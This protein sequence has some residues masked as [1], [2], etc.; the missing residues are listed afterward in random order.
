M[1]ERRDRRA[2]R[3]RLGRLHR[4]AYKFA[5]HTATDPAAGLGHPAQA[6]RRKTLLTQMRCPDSVLRHAR[7]AGPPKR[8]DAGCELASSAIARNNRKSGQYLERA[9]SGGFTQHNAKQ[10]VHSVIMGHF[11]TPDQ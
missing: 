9:T 3:Q 2:M 6:E 5:R 1:H 8:S 10:Q 7:L 4:D 11:C